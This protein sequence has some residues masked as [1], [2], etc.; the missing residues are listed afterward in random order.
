MFIIS[1]QLLVWSHVQSLRLQTMELDKETDLWSE[2]L[3]SF[4]V[5]KDTLFR[6]KY[7][8]YIFIIFVL[9]Y[10]FILGTEGL[11]IAILDTQNSHTCTTKA[12]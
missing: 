12:V 5:N 10:T 9:M 11:K 1:Y 2:M 6:Y 4:H 8:I 3:C 7:N